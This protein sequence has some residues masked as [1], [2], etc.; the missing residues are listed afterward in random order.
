ML[1]TGSDFSA[2]SDETALELALDEFR[3]LQPPTEGLSPELLT[4]PLPGK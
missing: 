2:T 1:A 3:F 4:A